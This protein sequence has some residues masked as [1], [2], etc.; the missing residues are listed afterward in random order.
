MDR[1]AARFGESA[2]IGFDFVELGCVVFPTRGTA[3]QFL[4]V[5]HGV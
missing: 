3:E 2:Y 1:G 5:A 4:H